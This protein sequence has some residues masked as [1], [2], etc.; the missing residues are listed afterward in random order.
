MQQVALNWVRKIINFGDGSFDLTSH[1]SSCPLILK[2]WCLLTNSQC[3]L[4]LV[5]WLITL[6]RV[7]NPRGSE[8]REILQKGHFY[9]LL[10]LT[11]SFLTKLCILVSRA[12]T[13]VPFVFVLYTVL[14]VPTFMHV[15]SCCKQK[16]TPWITK[17][18]F[19]FM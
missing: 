9:F 10:S 5:L 17:E 4:S 19:D 16:C 11:H 1:C 7:W 6:W 13:T 2:I 3:L 18:T 8:A 14:F 12:W 15:K